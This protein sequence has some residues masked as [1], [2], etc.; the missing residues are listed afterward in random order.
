MKNF[1]GIRTELTERK[2]KADGNLGDPKNESPS[3]RKGEKKVAKK[4]VG[5]LT[6]YPI[7]NE[8]LF[9]GA[10]SPSGDK[11]AGK[12]KK[13]VPEEVK[14]EDEEDLQE[15]VYA[16][17]E[18]IVKEKQMQ[19]VKFANKKSMTVDG[20]TANLLVKV[21]KALKPANAEKFKKNLNQGPNSFM[22]M[23]D[24]AFGQV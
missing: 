10:T 12:G 15:D 16:T 21:V 8:K 20:I 1:R 9:S 11:A 3:N 19:K 18:K 24:F 4:H 14:S 13:L 17:L 22:K 23:V 5:D 6:D 7:K 2:S